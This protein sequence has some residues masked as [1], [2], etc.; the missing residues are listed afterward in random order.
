MYIE[1][2]TCNTLTYS[3]YSCCSSP[4]FEYLWWFL[5]SNI[6]MIWVKSIIFQEK[7]KV[8]MFGYI[9]SHTN[10][11]TWKH[12]EGRGWNEMK[13]SKSHSKI[14]KWQ[15]SRLGKRAWHEK[16]RGGSWVSRIPC[17]V[18][19]AGASS[20]PSRISDVTDSIVG[21][22]PSEMLPPCYHNSVVPAHARLT[23]WPWAFHRER[24]VYHV[25]VCAYVNIKVDIHICFFL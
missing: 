6:A 14:Q 12:P 13:S 15:C 5:P 10:R 2:V 16:R 9:Q 19:F 1:H 20:I 7:T 3:P 24:N 23:C 22:S 11:L 17:P 8:E 4:I 21:H 25:C 18:N